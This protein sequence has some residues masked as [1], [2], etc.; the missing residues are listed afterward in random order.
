MDWQSCVPTW[1]DDFAGMVGLVGHKCPTCGR[2]ASFGLVLDGIPR[3]CKAHT[4]EGQRFPLLLIL[5][6]YKVLL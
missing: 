3:T 2:A 1:C 4:E 5:V 6:A